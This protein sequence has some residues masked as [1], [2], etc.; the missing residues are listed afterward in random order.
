MV[1]SAEFILSQVMIL[2]A[3]LALFEHRPGFPWLGTEGRP[4]GEHP[5]MVA[6][7][8]VPVH[9]HPFPAGPRVRLLVLGS[10]RYTLERLRIKL[11]FLIL[12]WALAAVPRLSW[13]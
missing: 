7:P 13:C 1:F 11:P 5:P 2:F 4:S 10:S 12:P 6:L 3:A 8:A 9:C